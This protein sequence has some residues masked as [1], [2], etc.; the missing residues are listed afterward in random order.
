MIGSKA[1]SYSA[2]VVL[3]TAFISACGSD[4]TGPGSIDSNA[5]LQSLSL[6]LQGVGEVGSPTAPQIHATFVGIAPLLDQV[7]VTID[8]ASQSMFALG[9]RET[10]PDGTC[11]E[12][13]FIGPAFPPEPGVCT[14]PELGLAVILWQTHSATQPPDRMFLI[15]ADVGTS[16]FDFASSPYDYGSSPTD[17]L[18]AVAFYMEGEDNI[19]SSL[20][21]TL[22]S[23]VTA[24]SQTCDLWLPPYAKSAVCNFATFDE[25]GSIVFEPFLADVPSTRR[26]SLVISRQTLDGLWLAITEVQPVAF[27]AA[28]LLTPSLLLRATPARWPPPARAPLPVAP[29]R[30]RK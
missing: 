7:N 20:S 4:S 24:T 10:F 9:L 18:P 11:E 30:F 17:R 5:A 28:R 13:L 23:Q 25:Q 27:S 22:S 1:R 15:V 3:A 16:N 12:T 21:G 26:L 6:G 29:D 14:P 2:L 8:G 19:W